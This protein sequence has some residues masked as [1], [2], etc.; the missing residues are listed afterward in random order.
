MARPLWSGVISFGLINIPVLV[1]SAKEDDQLHFNMLD[2]RDHARIGYKQINKKTGEEVTRKNIVKGYEYESDQFVILTDEDFRRANPKATQTI[3]IQDFVELSDLDP[4]LF[5]RPY[6]MLPGK[7]GKKAYVLLRKVIQDSQKVA[8]ATMVMFKKQRLVALMARG[9]FIILEVLRYAHQVL[10]VTEAD[11]FD[12]DLGDVKISPKELSM[13]TKLVEDMVSKWNP[14]KYKDTYYDDVMKMIRAKVKKGGTVESEKV[15]APKSTGK[16]I[17]LMP[18]LEESLAA[19]TH[20]RK[21]G[22]ST[23]GSKR[24]RKGA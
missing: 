23:A 8:I 22:K 11:V 15:E 16:V 17:D 2:K 4:L 21:K 6:Y 19:T 9:D 13:A 18:L 7:G 12:Q 5:E 20:K 24:T 10:D 1:M 14:S 3:D